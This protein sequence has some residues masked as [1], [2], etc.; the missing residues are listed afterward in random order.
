M[1]AN[2][3][4]RT[5]VVNGERVSFSLVA[6]KDDVFRKL[7]EVVR[8]PRLPGDQVEETMQ[9]AT[10]ARVVLGAWGKPEA[11]SLCSELGGGLRHSARGVFVR[12]PRF[13]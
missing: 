6:D 8:G 12:H 13:L 2:Y 7:E 10:R 3:T 4:V 1:F 9:M 5:V 11:Y